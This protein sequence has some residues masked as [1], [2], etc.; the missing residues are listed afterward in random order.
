MKEN[1]G[2]RNVLW[3]PGIGEAPP[4]PL[5]LPGLPHPVAREPRGYRRS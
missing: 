4:V 2:I 1:G 5:L 3:L